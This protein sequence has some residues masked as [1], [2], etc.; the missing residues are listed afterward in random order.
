LLAF[1]ACASPEEYERRADRAVD[2][3]LGGTAQELETQRRATNLQPERKP[4]EP[5]K[6]EDTTAALPTDPEARRLSL[7]ESLE[8]AIATNREYLTARDALYQTALS[9]TGTRH[10]F[11]PLLTSTLRYAFAG[12]DHVDETQFLTW[13]AGLS[14]KLPTGGDLSLSGAATVNDNR[15]LNVDPTTFDAAAAIQLTQPLLRGAGEEVA[16]EALTQA[17]RNLMY[18]IRDF[19]LFRETF[20]IDVAS[21][22]YSLVRQHQE[23]NNQRRNIDGLVFARKQ[24]EAL[25]NVDRVNELEVLRARRNELESENDLIEAEENYRLALDRFRIFLGLPENVH[26]DVVDAAPDFVEVDYDVD[27]AVEVALA[28]RLDVINRTEQLADVE[29]ALSIAENGLL[30][31]LNLE[32][33][34]GIASDVVPIWER[35]DVDNGTWRLGLSLDLPVDQLDERNAYRSAQIAYGRA[36]RDY[37]RFL[38]ELAVEVRS[39]FRGLVRRKQ[40]MDIQRQLISDQERNVT[41]AQIRLERGEVSNREVIEAQESLLQARNSLIQEQV[42]YEIARLSLLRDLGILFIDEHGMWTE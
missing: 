30:P 20:S 7:S 21:R 35:S 5:A 13:T 9:L 2:G 11:S 27:S 18:A 8:V 12:G 39:T 25:R 36:K 1:A 31:D 24:A 16:Y 6:P 10:D 42:D 33:G 3:I 22:Y 14:K 23:L 41:I 4:P 17:E 40:S 32:L 34:Y 19:E 37:E 28:N 29:R 38:Q 15:N 26:V